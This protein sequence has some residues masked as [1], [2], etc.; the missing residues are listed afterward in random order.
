MFGIYCRGKSQSID[1]WNFI[2]SPDTK[3]TLSFCMVCY[4]WAKCTECTLI[5]KRCSLKSGTWKQQNTVLFKAALLINVGGTKEVA[6]HGDSYA[7][8][9]SLF[10]TTNSC[11]ATLILLVPKV[12]QHMKICCQSQQHMIQIVDK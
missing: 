7:A 8:L 12:Y 11:Y 1:C 10:T 9:L 2:T 3:T 5:L 6:Y 4:V